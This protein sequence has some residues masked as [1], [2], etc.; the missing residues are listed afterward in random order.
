MIYVSKHN[1]TL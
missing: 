1:V